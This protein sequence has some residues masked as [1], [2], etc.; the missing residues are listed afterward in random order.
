MNTISD[1]SSAS[2]VWTE[3]SFDSQSYI[4]ID[5]LATDNQIK[6]KLLT[7]N[8]AQ[9]LSTKQNR[10]I[11]FTTIAILILIIIVLL[12]TIIAIRKSNDNPTDHSNI[13]T[14]NINDHT[15]IFFSDK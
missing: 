14:N 12:A 13:S 7:L 15:S 8:S 2:V 5:S 9:R 10:I 6:K 3:K 4:N 11:I 1:I